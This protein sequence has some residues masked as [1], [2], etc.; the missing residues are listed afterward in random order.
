MERSGWIDLFSG[1]KDGNYMSLCKLLK[2]SI[3]IKIFLNFINFVVLFI[4]IQ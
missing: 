3:I 1:I 4:D 2:L